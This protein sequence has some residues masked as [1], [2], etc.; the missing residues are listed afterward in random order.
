LGIVFF[1]MA[2]YALGFAYIYQRRVDANYKLLETM[3][4][5]PMPRIAYEMILA[6]NAEKQGIIPLLANMGMVLFGVGY[7]ACCLPNLKGFAV[8]ACVVLALNVPMASGVE[9]EMVW[10]GHR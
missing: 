6:Y 2:L 10:V 1:C 4:G 7:L 5:R 3:E 9:A 8:L